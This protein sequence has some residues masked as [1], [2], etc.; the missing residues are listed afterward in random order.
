V[1][2]TALVIAI[3]L[4]VPA[5]APEGVLAAAREAATTILRSAGIQPIW[6]PCRPGT[7]CLHLQVLDRRIASHGDTTGYTVADYAVVSYPTAE[8]AA[9]SCGEPPGIVLGA[10]M[11]HE[12]GHLLLP[13]PS[14]STTGVMSPRL[15]CA[16]LRLAARGELRFTPDQ[17]RA[18]HL[19]TVK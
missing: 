1:G 6:A 9:E 10:A 2:F 15:G 17:V 5:S 8:A 12:L 3:H 13:S 16:E 18:L 19:L 4:V 11:A 7:R 14:H